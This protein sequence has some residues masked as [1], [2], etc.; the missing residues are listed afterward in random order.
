MAITI[1]RMA[2]N[3]GGA[4]LSSVADPRPPLPGVAKYV[5]PGDDPGPAHA[6]DS[7]G[8]RIYRMDILAGQ[9]S[10]I[11]L[12]G[13]QGQPVETNNHFN[14]VP[15]SRDLWIDDAPN[16]P[17][18]HIFFHGRRFPQSQAPSP[19]HTSLLEIGASPTKRTVLQ[20][21]VFDPT[22]FQHKRIVTK[23]YGRSLA[24]NAEGLPA[25]QMESNASITGGKSF[26]DVVKNVILKD[27]EKNKEL[28]HLVVNAHGVLY[29]PREKEPDL[30]KRHITIHLGL[31]INK[32]N[33]SEWDQ[34]AGKVRYIWLQCC[35]VGS[36]LSF[37][38]EV[39][40]RTGALVI[41]YT[42]ETG[43]APPGMA[44]R[45][46]DVLISQMKVWDGPQCKALSTGE[47]RA[48]GPA[49]FWSDARYKSDPN[50]AQSLR[51]NMLHTIYAP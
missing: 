25:Y 30:R 3:I 36:D 28:E 10:A 18:R 15:G 38:G 23:L 27:I 11:T 39:A 44:D 49:S 41:G 19:H 47:I 46:I 33:L 34:L 45:T 35:T 16:A 51:F 2:F 43:E 17:R 37:C 20:V 48:N 40:M 9:H 13:S 31:G 26:G 12:V 7:A 22:K 5:Q 8:G 29:P 50:L 6:Y 42:T 24:L 4:R 14:A 32:G 1:P 21:R